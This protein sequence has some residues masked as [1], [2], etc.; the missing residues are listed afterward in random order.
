MKLSQVQV[1]QDFKFKNDDAKH[2]YKVLYHSRGGDVVIT[3]LLSDTVST[4]HE[5]QE[6][7]LINQKETG[8]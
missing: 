1:L 2:P 6:V 4:I 7:F 3:S 8:K 5:D